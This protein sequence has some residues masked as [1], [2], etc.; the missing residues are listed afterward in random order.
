[1][2]DLR[3]SRNLAER[4][5][6]QRDSPFSYP[7]EESVNTF[8]AEKISVDTSTVLLYSSIIN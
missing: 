3:D 2:E 7:L 1:M 6:S 8:L 5:G 4:K